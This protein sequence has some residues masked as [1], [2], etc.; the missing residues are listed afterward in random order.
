M[1]MLVT[2]LYPL[3]PIIG[4]Y[5]Y[6]MPC[7]RMALAPHLMIGAMLKWQPNILNTKLQSEC[8]SRRKPLWNHPSC[9]PPPPLPRTPSRPLTVMLYKILRASNKSSK[10]YSNDYDYLKMSQ[11][12]WKVC[13]RRSLFPGQSWLSSIYLLDCSRPHTKTK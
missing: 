4:H 7:C 5:E 8:D 9:R 10:A 2:L 6:G 13:S 3:C 11:S 1:N 12:F